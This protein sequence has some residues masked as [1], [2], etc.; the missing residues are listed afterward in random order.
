MKISLRLL[1]VL[2][3]FVLIAVLAY[4]LR[5]AATPASVAEEGDAPLGPLRSVVSALDTQ[6]YAFSWV[7]VIV[8]IPRGSGTKYTYDERLRTVKFDRALPPSV[9]FPGEYG[10]VPHTRS[11]DGRALE[12]IVLGQEPTYPGVLIQARP[13]GLIL[14]RIAAGVQDDKVLAVPALDPGFNAVTDITNLPLSM[15][16]E[17]AG[18]F[19]TFTNLD[20]KRAAVL[21]WGDAQQ[22]RQAI[23]QARVAYTRGR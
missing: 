9:R 21:G 23:L 15:R 14:M 1:F 17:V 6:E 13:I 19:R 4:I 8:E 10:V 20:G 16:E 5:G 22:A 18:F 2:A 3:F 7:D 12:V 11:G